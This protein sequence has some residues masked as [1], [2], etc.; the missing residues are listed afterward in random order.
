LTETGE[1]LTELGEPLTET[2]EPLTETGERLTGLYPSLTEDVSL[3]RLSAMQP[4]F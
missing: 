1:P 2:G 3:A 4:S